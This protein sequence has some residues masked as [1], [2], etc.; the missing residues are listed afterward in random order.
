MLNG[1]GGGGLDGGLYTLNAWCGSCMSEDIQ[2]RV[3]DIFC[4]DM[5]NNSRV[6]DIVLA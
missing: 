3:I 1:R 5:K 4:L 6:M 2:L